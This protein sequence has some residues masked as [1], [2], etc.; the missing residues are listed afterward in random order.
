[1]GSVGRTD[2]ISLQVPE[3]AL[4]IKSKIAI[5]RSLS[6]SLYSYFY[7][8]GLMIW[9]HLSY[10]YALTVDGQVFTQEARDL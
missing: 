4:D 2:M 5:L 8:V 6:M 3:G 1:M 7:H 9:L 10:I